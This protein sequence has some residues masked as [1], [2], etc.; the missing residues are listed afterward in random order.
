MRLAIVRVL[1]VICTVLDLIGSAVLMI[2]GFGCLGVIL[3]FGGPQ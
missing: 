3:M 2:S 1:A